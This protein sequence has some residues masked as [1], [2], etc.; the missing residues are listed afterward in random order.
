MS[1]LQPYTGE[2]KI[3]MVLDIGMTFSGISYCILK[4]GQALEV[5]GVARQALHVLGLTCLDQ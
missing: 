3:V 4:W 2:P 5:N 1:F